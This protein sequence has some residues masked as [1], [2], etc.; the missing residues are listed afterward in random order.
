MSHTGVGGRD[1]PGHQ[2]GVRQMAAATTIQ[3]AQQRVLFKAIVIH[4]DMVI[5]RV[6]AGASSAART[7]RYAIAYGQLQVLTQVA[8]DILGLGFTPFEVQMAI[9]KFAS[10]AEAGPMPALTATGTSARIPWIMGI[11]DR[12]IESLS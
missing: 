9:A 12:I 1:G 8:C 7:K 5:Q 4:Q 2:K 3:E 10:A 11:A 6:E